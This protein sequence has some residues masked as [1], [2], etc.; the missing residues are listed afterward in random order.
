MTIVFCFFYTKFSFL[1]KTINS[2][3]IQNKTITWLVTWMLKQKKIK[4][5]FATLPYICKKR[6]SITFAKKKLKFGKDFSKWHPQICRLSSFFQINVFRKF[7]LSKSKRLKISNLVGHSNFGTPISHLLIF[8]Y[9]FLFCMQL[10]FVKCMHSS[11]GGLK[12]L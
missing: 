10:S 5:R 6:Y 7:K 2:N 12:V 9:N 1:N 4:K 3:F 11:R 8:F